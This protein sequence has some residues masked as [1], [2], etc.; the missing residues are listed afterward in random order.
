M[1]M[2]DPDKPPSLGGRAVKPCVVMLPGLLCDE[3]V[4]QEQVKALAFAN[5]IVPSFG[6]LSSIVDM[7]RHV[8]RSVPEPR[9][10]L[11]GHSMG[12]RV[13]LEIAR[14]APERLDRIALLDSGMDPI[15]SG[16]SGR[17][18]RE[19]RASLLSLAGR[20]GMR[21]MG[22]QW[23]RGMVH[24]SRLDSPLFEDILRMIERQTPAIFAAQIEALLGRPDA[25]AV[26]TSLVCPTLI[27]CGRQDG[28]S[29]L[30]RHEQMH[31]L[32]PHSELV[33]IED[34]GHM[35][36]M[37]QPAAVSKAL[38]AWISVVR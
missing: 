14:L 13:A 7:A 21:R 18:E 24:P 6:E 23:A 36:T 16:D 26:L 34:S 33:V 5:C 11:V 35:S 20:H 8:L 12:G 22:L 9:F 15:A 37:E 27:A 29:P 17:R 1:L 3:A 30:S 10:S 28:W 32:C 25:R 31:A 4:W 2:A 38:A 19:Q